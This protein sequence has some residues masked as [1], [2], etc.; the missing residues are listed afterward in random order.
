MQLITSTQQEEINNAARNASARKKQKRNASLS[1]FQ[2]YDDVATD[3]DTS[4]ALPTNSALSTVKTQD[5]PV[6]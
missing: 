1:Y 2:L 6:P 4:S 5:V 3:F